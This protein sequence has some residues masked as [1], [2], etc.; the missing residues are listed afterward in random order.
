MIGAL[1]AWYGLYQLI[2]VAVNARGLLLL[3]QGSIDFPA[4][5]P[6]EGW[7]PQAIHFFTA[8]AALDLINAL[9]ALVFVV[10]YFRKASWRWWLGTLTLTISVYAALVFDYT[11]LASGAWTRA[12]LGG[13]LLINLPFLPVMGLFAWLCVQGFRG[14]LFFEREMRG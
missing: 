8:M 12:N 11:T 2:H 13:Y 14:S 6:P 9:L 10:G 1:V 5:P 3:S 7:T 4:L